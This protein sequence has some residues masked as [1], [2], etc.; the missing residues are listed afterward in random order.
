VVAG[1]AGSAV[2]DTPS[3]PSIVVAAAILFVATLA[4]PRRA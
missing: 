1:L 3:G 4:V 2:F